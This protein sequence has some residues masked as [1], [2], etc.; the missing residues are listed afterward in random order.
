MATAIAPTYDFDKAVVALQADTGTNLGALLAELAT[1]PDPKVRKGADIATVERV[2]ETL[3][4]NIAELPTVFNRVDPTT[5]RALNK[6]ELAKLL[7][8]KERIDAVE[9]ATKKR[10]ERIHAILSDHFDVIAERQKLVSEDTPTDDKG[11][12]LI[13]AKGAPETQ[14]IA[15][16]DRYFTRERTSD[17]TVFSYQT[18]L[19]LYEAREISRAD[20]LACTRPVRTREIDEDKLRR[21]L[22]SKKLRPRAQRLISMIGTVKRGRLSINL[23]GSK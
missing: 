7:E 12:Y 17:T 8:E 15:G 22:L 19:A 1:T 6:T 5:K 18:L 10:K 4:R 23:R 14:S 20:Y 21:M 9:K 11:H 16:S 13:A 3:M 2:G